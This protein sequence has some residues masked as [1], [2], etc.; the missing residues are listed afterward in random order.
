MTR[1]KSITPA[2]VTTL[3]IA[4]AAYYF[5]K[6]I[7][8]GLSKLQAVAKQAFEEMDFETDYSFDLDL[9]DLPQPPPQMPA[10]S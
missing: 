7:G 2:L 10:M 9:P 8:Q 3:V 4:S 6:E 1:E 5:R